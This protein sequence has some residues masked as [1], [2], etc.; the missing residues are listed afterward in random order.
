[1]NRGLDTRLRRLERNAPDPVKAALDS[2]SDE[3]LSTALAAIREANAGGDVDLSTLPE[4][5]QRF[6][7]TWAERSSH[8]RSRHGRALR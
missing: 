5:V 6:F 7:E 4:A 3:D 8:G 2:L 1:M